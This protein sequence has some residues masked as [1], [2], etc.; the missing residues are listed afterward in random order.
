MKAAKKTTK[1]GAITAYI[2]RPGKQLGGPAYDQRI[3]RIPVFFEG[4]IPVVA[5]IIKV[6][7]DYYYRVDNNPL[8]YVM[9]TF[10]KGTLVEDIK[11][12]K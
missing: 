6:D 2:S 1:V 12:R 4:G 10:S 9:M 8:R 11:G 5:E 7:K 3:A